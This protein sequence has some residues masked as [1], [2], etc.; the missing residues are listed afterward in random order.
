MWEILVNSEL[1]KTAGAVIL[2]LGTSYIVNIA[3]KKYANHKAAK[4]AAE[5]PQQAS[6][7]DGYERAMKQLGLRL[8]EAGVTIQQMKKDFNDMERRLAA[9]RQQRLVVEENVY[10]ASLKYH[11][12][13]Q[14]VL[15]YNQS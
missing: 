8:E 5:N 14:E 12:D 11:F 3:S 4:L 10:R 13:P 1:V 15:Q 6:I 7:Y 2:G 9:E